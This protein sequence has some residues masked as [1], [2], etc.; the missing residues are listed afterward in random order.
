MS[1]DP[2]AL[3][4]SADLTSSALAV[5]ERILGTVPMETRGTISGHVGALH[6]LLQNSRGQGYAHLP[7]SVTGYWNQHVDGKHSGICLSVLLA[8]LIADMKQTLA[9]R[10]LPASIAAEAC[11]Q[12]SR[13]LKRLSAKPG[14]KMMLTSDTF[15]KELAICRL[16][17]FACGATLAEPYGGPR[18]QLLVTAGLPGALGLL[19]A[20]ARE[21]GITTPYLSLHLH[22]PLL[23]AFN[24][25]GW[26]KAYLL[27]AE[28]LE[29]N[30]RLRGVL[31]GGWYCD[32]EMQRVSPHLTY[33]REIADEGGALF[34]RGP[35]SED[36]VKSATIAP[37]SRREDFL[38][39]RYRPAN[40]VMIWL[41]KD[42]LTW[43]RAHAKES[44]IGK[45]MQ[46][47]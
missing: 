34:V 10:N 45:P 8:T 15:L 27:L 33:I 20:L 37:G 46:A 42:V 36:D 4:T 41:R 6:E 2:P 24:P 13:I 7:P 16:E 28:L 26:R 9:A 12:G 11:E 39:G 47:S 25:A 18:R 21:R 30:P 43:A 22:P 29:W 3:E 5:R 31:G 1:S 17:M 44:D 14:A 23:H 38:A 35:T 32:P 40:Y 19:A